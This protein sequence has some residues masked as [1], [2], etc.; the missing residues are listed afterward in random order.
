VRIYVP[1]REVFTVPLAERLPEPS[2]I[3][4]HFA[5]ASIYV[6]PPEMVSGE[7][8]LR[9]IRGIVLSTTVTLRETV[10]EIFPAVSVF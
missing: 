3:S 6:V 9:M 4:N 7:D 8:Q 5:Q 2:T 1:E 10:L